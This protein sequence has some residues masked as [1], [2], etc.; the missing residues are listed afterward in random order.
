MNI[1]EICEDCVEYPDLQACVVGV[2]ERYGQP[3]TICYDIDRVIA[4]Y[5]TDGCTYEEAVEHFEFC[6]LGAYV[7]DTTPCFLKKVGFSGD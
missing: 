7:G 6:V 1:E 5:M 2:V 4:H 3:P